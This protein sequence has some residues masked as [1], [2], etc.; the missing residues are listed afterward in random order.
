LQAELHKTVVFV[1][2]DITSGEDGHSHR[3]LTSVHSSVRHTGD[4]PRRPHQSRFRRADARSNA[5][6]H[7]HSADEL[8][9]TVVRADA[10]ASKVAAA[11]DA[12]A[13]N[14]ALVV[15]ADA[16]DALRSQ[17]VRREG[18]PGPRR[19]DRSIESDQPR[20]GA[21]LVLLRR[22]GIIGSP[23]SP[24]DPDDAGTTDRLRR[25]LSESIHWR[26]L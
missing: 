26:W 13:A 19:S 18:T 16:P 9:G 24:V 21:R 11:L 7:A 6:G 14:R 15:D 12:A 5:A 8:Q 4:D 3:A 2:H 10:D 25:S 22:S 1:T 23:P 20:S 17:D